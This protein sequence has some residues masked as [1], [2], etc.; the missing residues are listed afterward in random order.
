MRLLMRPDRQDSGDALPRTQEAWD[1]PWGTP[2]L[3]ATRV[4]ELVKALDEERLIV[5]VTVEASPEDPDHKP[6]DP[7]TSPLKTIDSPYGHSVVAFTSAHEL[8]RWDPSGRP[9]TM[10]A[11]RVAV[12]ALAGNGS[13][14]ITLNPGSPDRTV[15]PRPAVLALSAGDRWLPAWEDHQLRDQLR[16]QAQAAC[17]GIINVR[18]RP[19]QAYG[20]SKWDGIVAVDIVVDMGQVLLGAG[21]DES[22]ARARFGA[23]M[24]V[25]SENPRLRE[26][27]QQV[28][29]V[30]RPASIA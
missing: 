17:P 4:V 3:A 26:A 22:L 16:S 9:M 19:E 13:G 21:G 14:T 20:S 25:I 29:L 7:A 28:E 5:P 30:P 11:Y 10:K 12:A 23:A 1:L 18:L 6:L 2:E 15:I 27:S 8:K 24:K